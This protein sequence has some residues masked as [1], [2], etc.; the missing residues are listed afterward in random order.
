M[1]VLSHRH[2]LAFV[3]V[4]L[5]LAGQPA[6]ASL[7]SAYHQVREGI[8]RF[9]Q[10]DFDGAA[11][12]FAEAD[13]ALPEDDRIAF[14]RACVY[15]AKRDAAKSVELFQ[16]AAQSEDTQV[17]AAARYNLGGIGVARA[18]AVFGDQAAEAPP[19]KRETGV[20][21]LITAIAHY[22]D[23]LELSP[24]HEKARKNIEVLR[25]WLKHMQDVWARRDREQ[26]RNE[27]D[28]L[29]LLEMITERQEQLHA[30]TQAL[31]SEADSPRRRQ[32]M[33]ETGR[34]Q[35]DLI[36]EVDALHDKAKQSF[37]APAGTSPANAS[38]QSEQAMSAFTGMVDE[39]RTAMTEAADRLD[40]SEPSDAATAQLNSL[41]TLNTIYTAVVPF[42]SLLQ[43]SIQVQ[44]RL[45]NESQAIV[46]QTHAEEAADEEAAG[47]EQPS[48]L[49]ASESLRRQEYIAGWCLALPQKAQVELE[50]LDAQSAPVAGPGLPAASGQPSPSSSNAQSSPGQPSPQDMKPALEKAID[51]AP[52][53]AEQAAAAVD[54]L[55]DTNWADA[56]PS[57][58]ETLRLLKEI[59]DQLPKQPKQDQNQGDQQQDKKNQEQQDQ[60]QNSPQPHKQPQNQPQPQQQRAEATLRKAKQRE[61]DYR[62]MQKQLQALMRRS[63]D[64]DKD[65]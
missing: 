16:Q 22:R 37:Q 57:Q 27:M 36:D 44:E 58:Q 49:Q 34:S 33:R 46:D 51:L 21:H 62:D 47:E 59:A 23:C 20:Q 45:M 65:W 63:N 25:L 35:R 50:Q 7:G 3:F 17:A 42:Q 52:Q 24:N 10:G 12:A 31:V 41:Q 28:L 9:V 54:S 53:A 55:K 19:E 15:L 39:V 6:H 26:Q 1:F 4:L 43:K 8:A 32:A 30:V 61:Q 18:K 29:Q 64:V 60:Q 14:D 11:K 5:T 38:P 48:E 2:S 13:V 40:A 56:L